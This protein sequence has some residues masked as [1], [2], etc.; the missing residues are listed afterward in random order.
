MTDCLLDADWQ[1]RLASYR[2]LWVGFSGGLDSTVLLHAIASQPMLASKLSAVHIH[3][4]LSSNAD[5]WLAHCQTICDEHG[6]P[7]STHHVVLTQPNNIEEQARIARLTVFKTLV[8]EHDALVLGHH[9]D[10]QAETLL[11]QL[12]RGAGVDGLAAMPAV[13]SFYKGELVRPLLRHSRSLLETY[14]RM[15]QLSW[16]EDESNQDCGYSRNYLRHEVMPI[17]RAR[18]PNVVTN[19]A[20]TATHCQQAKMN[21]SMLATLDNGN[22]APKE[23][24]LS[25]SSLPVE[26]H[27]R[28]VNML[29]VWLT[30]NQ[31]QL[32][33][34]QTFNRLIAEIVMASEDAV[35]CVE[36]GDV[37]IRRY[38]QTLYIC[39][40]SEHAHYP[41]H[42]EWPF[43]PAT[44]QWG[45][46]HESVQATPTHKGLFVPP[47]SR[48]SVRTRQGGERFCWHGQTKTLKKLL[49]QWHV[50]PWL[51]DTLPLIYINDEL[52][53]VTG[54]AIND[55]HYDVDKP[56]IYTIQI[57]IGDL[58]HD[59]QEAEPL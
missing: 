19:L 41:S 55:K 31:I 48:I 59:R 40:L 44:L 6:I 18:W 12:F 57:L 22:I 56:N 51:R 1:K 43:F 34:T 27:A 10:D 29:R 3:H 32:P 52:A 36:W 42:L 46:A 38:Q 2:T 25:I 16:I 47:G 58:S 13:K 23:R 35:P 9:C 24:T 45:D 20:R 7:L 49:Q 54:Y 26:H 8:Q 5:A 33:S 53:A 50:P 17:L 15:H 11:L 37:S 28:C 39:K 30:N 4:G 14:A 21:L